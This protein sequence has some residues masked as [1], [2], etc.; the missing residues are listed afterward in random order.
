MNAE[1]QAARAVLAGDSDRP[2]VPMPVRQVRCPHCEAAPGCPCVIRTT[3]T[4]L[5]LI[6]AHP[7]RW[8]VAGVEMPPPRLPSAPH[9]AEQTPPGVASRGGQPNAATGQWRAVA[10]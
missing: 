7:S 9:S 3:D 4:P 1:Y 8:K 6:G 5:R 10:S 2:V